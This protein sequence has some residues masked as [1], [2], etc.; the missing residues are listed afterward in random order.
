MNEHAGLFVRLLRMQQ[1]D[2]VGLGTTE[3]RR[4]KH[5]K[6]CKRRRDAVLHGLGRLPLANVADLCWECVFEEVLE[7]RYSCS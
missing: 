2:T 6:R 4:R 5:W 1:W 7:L 3:V